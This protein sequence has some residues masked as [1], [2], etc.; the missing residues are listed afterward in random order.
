MPQNL[1]NEKSAIVNTFWQRKN[2][3]HFPDDIFQSI[4][5]NE[6]IWILIK[7]SLKFVPRGPINNI[8]AFV[9]IMAWHRS[10]SKPLSETMMA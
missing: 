1:T 3:H 6:N 10:G 4:Y 2:G 7:I 5:L 9:Q 8:P